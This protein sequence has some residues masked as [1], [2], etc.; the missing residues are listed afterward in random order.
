MV[1]TGAND[2]GLVSSGGQREKGRGTNG[3]V[4]HVFTRHEVKTWR[5]LSLMNSLMRLNF[6][7]IKYMFIL[8]F[9]VKS[10]YFLMEKGEKLATLHS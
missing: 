3:W 7:N 1:D 10:V 2:W 4:L 8:S 5:K 9:D 6:T